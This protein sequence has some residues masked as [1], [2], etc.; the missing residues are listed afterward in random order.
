MF[1][2]GD[3]IK[4]LFPFELIFFFAP[5]TH[6]PAKILRLTSWI[7]LV[8]RSTYFWG[9]CTGSGPFPACTAWWARYRNSGC[10]SRKTVQLALKKRL[11]CM[12]A[13]S[14]SECYFNIPG[15]MRLRTG[16]NRPNAHM[17]KKTKPAPSPIRNCGLKDQMAQ[18]MLQRCRLLQTPRTTV[19]PTGAQL[20]AKGGTGEDSHI[21]LADWTLSVAAIEKDIPGNRVILS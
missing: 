18:H 8:K 7:L 19:R 21:Y 11:Q 13:C 10:R 5:G 1:L 20:H 12:H 17:F 16:H 14:K 6:Q 2:I 15:V 9:T 3:V 4:N